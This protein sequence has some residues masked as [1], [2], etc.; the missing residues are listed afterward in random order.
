MKT[1]AKIAGS[2]L[3]AL[4]LAV[5]GCQKQSSHSVWQSIND[6]AITNQLKSFIS[7]KQ[8][9]AD[10]AKGTA[11]PGFD[12]FMAAAQRGDREA[13]GRLGNQIEKQAMQANS[14]S[15][16]HNTRMQVLKEMIGTYDAF[17]D[18]DAKYS[19]LYGNE[20]IQSI[21]PGSIYFGGTDP[22][23]FIITALQPSQVKGDPFFTLTQNALAD[24]TYLDYLRAMYGDRIY[25]PTA[26]DSQKCFDDYY[27]DVQERMKNNQLQPG[28]NVFV[29][30]T[31][32]K[33]QVSGQVSV[34]M[35]NGLIVKVIFDKE[36]NREFYLE[37]SFPLAW[38]YPYLEPHGLIFK[39]NHQ[40]LTEL[41]D[42]IVDRDH[43]YWSKTISPMIG[44]WLQED[45]SIADI[46]A[47]NEKVFLNH[48]FSGFTGD[49][50]F[51]LTGYAHRM[52]SKERSSAGGLYAWRADHTKDRSGKEHMS[53]AA[54]FA[55]RQA[56]ALCPYS[57]EA[58]F[59]YVQF[60]MGEQ[61]SADALLVAETAAKFPGIDGRPNDAV[62]G[63]VKQ[64][65][66]Y[67][68]R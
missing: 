19:A 10:S 46:A 42:D 29:D 37:E 36:T 61:R 32:G 58:V 27:T 26:E 24:G 6:P 30:P 57:P 3:F 31:T 34:M 56:W 51:I 47:F 68:H 50:N 5:S 11:F 67:Q 48:D 28:E 25:I 1:T 8:A 40:P 63:L 20:I 55:F 59:R 66:Q 14:D 4:G 41:S 35:I 22:G 49:T 39:L 13:V 54:D 17:G 52:Y 18:S 9:Q 15:R 38:M 64:L 33:M 43:D 45:T 16:W 2:I 21:P 7:E 53:R 23:R 65:R 12:S 60:L 44:D 62:K